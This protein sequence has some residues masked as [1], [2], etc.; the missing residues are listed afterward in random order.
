MEYTLKHIEAFEQRFRTT[1]VNSLGGFKS[2]ALIGTINEAGQTNL[3]IFNSFFH[4]GAHPPLFGF[5]VRPDSAERHTLDNIR[6][7]KFFT[8]NHV[9]AAFYRQAH[10]TSARYPAGISEF[11]EAGLTEEFKDGFAAPFVKE[12]AVKIGAEL[13]DVLNVPINGTLIVIAKILTVTL[14]DGVLEKD[15][16]IDL[17][18]SGSITCAGLDAYYTA[19]PLARLSYAKPNTWPKNKYEE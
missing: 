2:L 13:Q 5:V 8:V 14:P 12:S 19:T 15:G 7:R 17:V 11:T 16:F 4:V 1:F 3:A 6:E 9:S 18:K 10:Q